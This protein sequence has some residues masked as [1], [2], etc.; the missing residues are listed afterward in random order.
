MTTTAEQKPKVDL[1]I[2]EEDD[3]FEEFPTEGMHALLLDYV[4]ECVMLGFSWHRDRWFPG[5][6]FQQYE[7]LNL[8][9]N[10]MYYNVSA[11]LQVITHEKLNNPY[12]TSLQAQSLMLPFI[13]CSS[14][15]ITTRTVSSTFDLHLNCRRT[16][17]SV[18]TYYMF[19]L[20]CS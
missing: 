11:R 9:V 6:M 8:R 17:L 14:Q 2:L 18:I 1:G 5:Q 13:G 16:Y 15:F 3:E 20:G 4:V 7:R 19:R 10:V 12:I